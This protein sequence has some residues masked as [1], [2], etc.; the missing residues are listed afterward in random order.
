MLPS[1]L[2][3]IVADG[4][5]LARFLTSSSQYTAR[6]AKPAAFLPAPKGRETSVFRHGAE[7][8]DALWAIGERIVAGSRTIHGAAVVKAGDVRA[9]GLGVFAEE[10]PPRHATIRGWPWRDDDPEL[11]K[12]QQKELA[13]LVAS[14]ATLV[15][16]FP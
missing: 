8:A 6:M 2:P 10:P 16:R 1:G 13:I 3:E 15:W 4:E 9:S 11:Q 5:D 12:A 14:D 7:P